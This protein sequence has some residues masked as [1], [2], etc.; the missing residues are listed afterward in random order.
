[1]LVIQGSF[2]CGQPKLA[3]SLQAEMMAPQAAGRRCPI[4][5]K[6]AFGADF[7]HVRVHVR[8]RAE[9]IGAIALFRPLRRSPR[10]HGSLITGTP[11]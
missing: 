5:T 3:V 8:L 4:R 11:I 7:W 2:P 6:A 9:R 10:H 1:V